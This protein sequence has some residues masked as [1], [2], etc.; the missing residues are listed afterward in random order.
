MRKLKYSSQERLLFTVGQLFYGEGWSKSGI[1]RELGVSVTHVSRLLREAH[2]LGIVRITLQGPR[3]EAVEQELASTFGLR[4][5]RVIT[6]CEDDTVLR[7]QLGLEAA[8]VFA[9]TARPGARVGIGSGRTLFEMVKA[10]PERPIAVEIF[11]LALLADLSLEVRSVDATTLV[12]TLWFKCR[13]SAKALKGGLLS[14]PGVSF[15]ELCSL[16]KA[17]LTSRFVDTFQELVVNA[18]ALFF[19]GSQLRKDSQILDIAREHGLGFH[20]LQQRG[21]IGDLLFRTFGEGGQPIDLGIEH[22]AL[23]PDLETLRRLS[24]DPS[25]S[26]VLVAGGRE[27]HQIIHSGLEAGYFNMLVTD[28]ETAA[29]LLREVRR[30]TRG[31]GDETR[32]RRLR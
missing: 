16:V 19:S 31:V 27:K 30:G 10:L 18:D 9:R 32:P 15:A 6:A 1:A 4:D 26:I 22:Y 29:V 12:N 24:R 5:A 23:A 21:I 25:K 8:A 11:P 17:T 7:A 14:F 20:E 2:K 13:P 3:H 28:D